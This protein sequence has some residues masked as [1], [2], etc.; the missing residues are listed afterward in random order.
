MALWKAVFFS[1]SFLSPLISLQFNPQIKFAGA[2]PVDG[3]DI[4]ILEELSDTELEEICTS[5]GFELVKDKDDETGQLK[6]YTH[7]DYVDAARQCLNIES[8]M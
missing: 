6:K 3:H 1:I 8:E 2:S 4:L 7:Q 5:R